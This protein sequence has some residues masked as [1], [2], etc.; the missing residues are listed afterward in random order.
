MTCGQAWAFKINNNYDGSA[1]AVLVRVSFIICGVAIGDQV[2]ILFIERN[3][4]CPFR[5]T[6]FCTSS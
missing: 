6:V 3:R 1:S 5:V 4:T 2:L